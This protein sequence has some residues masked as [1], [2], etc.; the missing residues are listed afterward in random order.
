MSG[1]RFVVFA[2]AASLLAG[3]AGAQVRPA[4]TKLYRIAGT[5]TDSVSN[6]SLGGATMTLLSVPEQATLQTTTTDDQGRFAFE[7]MAAGKYALMASRRGYLSEE[8]NEHENYSSA[9]V[10]GEGQDTEHIPFRLDRGGV[11]R[12]TVTDEKGDPVPEARVLIT[13]WSSWNGFGDQMAKPITSVA[14]D[15][16]EFEVWNLRPGRYVFAVLAYPWYALSPTRGEQ[17]AATTTEERDSVAALDV[18]FPLTYFDGVVDEGAAAPTEILPGS[19]NE[20]NFSLRAVPAA[21]I[22]V[23]VPHGTNEFTNQPSIFSLFFG[24]EI[25]TISTVRKIQTQ[26]VERWEF[27]VAPGRYRFKGGNPARIVDVDVHGDI[28]LDIGAGDATVETT[29]RVRMAD[30]SPLDKPLQIHLLGG[31]AFERNV[32]AMVTDKGEAR[33]SALPPGEWVAQPVANKGELGVVA[34]ESNG[35]AIGGSRIDFT[36]KQTGITLVLARGRTGV[37]GLA[38]KDGHGLAGAMIVLVPRD[39]VAFPADFRR[40]QSDSDGTFRLRG[41]IPGQYT[42]VAIEDGWG[43]DWR[44]PETI[45]RYLAEGVKVTVPESAPETI[46]L[47]AAVRVVKR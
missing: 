41:V 30:R 32:S 12:G 40:D 34:I 26:G 14:D 36:R 37:F 9:I 19:M 45:A 18:N 27:A 39:P 13:N 5:L 2:I 43:L 3:F 8:F 31:A 11:V 47:G 7:P 38:E 29:L 33:F 17:A 44:K 35:R 28:E 23:R 22:T 16:G 21:H 24:E 1:L 20:L 46:R 15:R 25:E 42:V 10:T 6:G 4:G